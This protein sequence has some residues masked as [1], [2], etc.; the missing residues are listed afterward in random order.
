[1]SKK[2]KDSSCPSHNGSK[3]R[4]YKCEYEANHKSKKARDKRKDRNANRRKAEK[5]G[6]VHKGDG[7]HLHSPSGH[8]TRG[9]KVVVQTAKENNNYWDDDRSDI[10]TIKKKISESLKAHWRKA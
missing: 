3:K 6:R 9:A 4:D 2:G 1:M 7:K 8:K 5:E 10:N